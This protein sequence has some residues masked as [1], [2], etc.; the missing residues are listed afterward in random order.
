MTKHFKPV[1]ALV[2]ALLSTVSTTYAQ[3]TSSTLS[4][5]LLAGSVDTTNLAFQLADLLIR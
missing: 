1:L 2:L 4:C 5:C 3:S